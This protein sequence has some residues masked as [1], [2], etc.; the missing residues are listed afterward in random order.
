M[1][2]TLSARFAEENVERENDELE[3]REARDAAER[4]ARRVRSSYNHGSHRGEY[5]DTH[6]RQKQRTD[7]QIACPTD[8]PT[9][10]PNSHSSPS[11]VVLVAMSR[12]GMAA[13]SA[14]TGGKN[15]PPI[16]RPPR[17]G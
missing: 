8:T 9:V 16:P 17:K 13:W 12:P 2:R 11:V 1:R 14:T 7:A 3:E 15:R 4:W 10:E 5:K 6:S